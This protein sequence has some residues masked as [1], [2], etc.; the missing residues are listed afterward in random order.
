MTSDVEQVHVAYLDTLY[1][2]EYFRTLRAGTRWWSR[3]LDLLIAL[4]TA[5]GGAT[6]FVGIVAKTP[7]LAWLCG[8]LTLVGGGLSIARSTYGWG[9]EI[10]A[11]TAVIKNYGQ[12][13]TEYRFLVDDLNTRRKWD[14]AMSKRAGE[15]RQRRLR[16]MPDDFPD[17]P[18]ATRQAIQARVRASV[19]RASWWTP[20][21][22][23]QPH[24]QEEPTVP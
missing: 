8:P 6:G 11:A 22:G 23:G 20:A 13:S 2:L 21:P 9:K 14:A 1:V 19:D 15:L 5:S 3:H 17:L 7:E 16:V 10:E 4:G 24:S 18:A 12:L